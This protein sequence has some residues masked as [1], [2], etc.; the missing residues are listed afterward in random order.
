MNS[1]LRYVIGLI[2]PILP[3]TSFFA[4]KCFLLR[5]TGAK[6]GNNVRICSSVKIVGSARL[7]IGND[8]WIG[9][10]VF[11]SL[12][13]NV[14]IGNCVDIAPRV[15]ICTGS[16]R[17]DAVGKHTAGEGYTETITI[18]NGVWI[19]IG[20]TILPGVFI[21]EKSMV[22]ACSLVN[23]SIPPYTVVKGIPAKTYCNL[24]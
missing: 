21:G 2:F 5:K 3:E 4:L 20:A 1:F 16:H 13:D 9:H 19:G 12:A 23:K 8:T 24:V 7:S 15:I 6:I 18:D 14:N 11:I 10:D 17:L 22:A